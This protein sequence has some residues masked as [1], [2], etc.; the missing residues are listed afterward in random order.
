MENIFD[1][2]TAQRFRERIQSVSSASPREWGTMSAGQMLE[3]CTRGIEM[4][5]GDAKLPRLLLGRLL[6]GIIKPLALKEGTPMRR[7]SPTAP[8]L[9]VPTDMDLETSRDRLLKAYDRFIQGGAPACTT[10]PHPF[11]GTLTPAQW[12]TLMYKHLDHHLRQFNA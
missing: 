12:S 7:N 8:A 9:V 6:G 4:T 2:P 3:H 10:H 11:F 1:P 5:T